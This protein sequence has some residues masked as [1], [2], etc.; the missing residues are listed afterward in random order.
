MSDAWEDLSTH[1]HWFG[2]YTFDLNMCCVFRMYKYTGIY[3]WYPS[4]LQWLPLDSMGAWRN[5]QPMS[6]SRRRPLKRNCRLG[7]W[8]PNLAFGEAPD[9][10]VLDIRPNNVLTSESGRK[11]PLMCGFSK[12]VIYLYKSGVLK[13]VFWGRD[14]GSQGVLTSAYLYAKMHVFINRGY[15]HQSR[16]LWIWDVRMA[17]KCSDFKSLK[18]LTTDIN[19]GKC[20]CLNFAK[21]LFNK[22]SLLFVDLQSFGNFD[23]FPSLG[24]QPLN[25]VDSK[26]FSNQLKFI[27]FLLSRSG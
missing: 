12:S 25:S 1:K 2:V 7:T 14:K 23:W 3:I 22:I 20:R 11:P 13:Y 10:H 21:R 17:S 9:P 4:T 6:R 5:D 27:Q 18:T 16:N 24:P 26:R 19:H 15:A 8:E